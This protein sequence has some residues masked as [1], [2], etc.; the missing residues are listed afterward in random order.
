MIKILSI[1]IIFISSLTLSFAQ[2]LNCQVNVIAP[3]LQG[4]SA[5]DEIM[6]TLEQSVFEMINNT[7]WTNDNY[8][9]EERIECS[10]LITVSSRTS[11]N[12]SG[13]IQVQSFRPVLN[14]SYRT[15]VFNYLD[16]DVDFKYL[17]NTA[18]IFKP[19]E[20]YNNLAD[21]IAYYAFIILGNDYDTFA[22]EGGTK[23]FTQAQQIVTNAQNATE[24]GWKSTESQRN[25]YW[26]IENILHNTFAPIR[27]FN[28]EYYRKGMDLF[29]DKKD[30]AMSNAL[31]SLAY[32]KEVHKVRPSSFSMQVLMLAKSSEFITLFKQGF[33][34][35]KPKAFAIL[36]EVDP[37]NANKYNEILR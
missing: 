16:K 11:D 23:F 14:S 22:L 9:I 37:A 24:P 34:N 7:K 10:I 33:P 4:N 32:L 15:Q 26:L 18:I 20:H 21:L 2:E 30:D 12:F 1:T 27:K 31:A 6:K 13:T 25:R 8:S 28:Y 19:T 36:K 17:R 5:N 35:Q 3:A 29:Y